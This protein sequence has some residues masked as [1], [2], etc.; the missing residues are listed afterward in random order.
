MASCELS[1]DSCDCR[2]PKE[3][4]DSGRGD[5]KFIITMDD[6]RN[7]VIAMDEEEVGELEGEARIR[8]RVWQPRKRQA[9]QTVYG[10]K[11]N[12]NQ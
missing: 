1:R 10:V 5:D 9:L 11:K 7:R 12:K 3:A 6:D 4:R 8:V 2:G